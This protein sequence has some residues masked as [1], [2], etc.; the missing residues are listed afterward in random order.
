MAETPIPQLDKGALKRVL[1]IADL[2]AVGYG[3]LGSSI[4]YALGITAMFA[5]GAT[6]I[7]LGLAGVVFICTALSYAE[8]TS[9]YHE[10][11]GS[12][13]YARHAF[14]D[15]ISF[16]AGWGLL[17]DYVVTIAISA[18]TIGPYLANFFPFLRHG[19]S[20][21]L[22]AIFLIAVLFLLNVRGIKQSTRIS[23]MLMLV[24]LITQLLIIGI[25]VVLTLNLPHLISQMKIGVAGASWSPSWHDFMH[26]TAMAMVA[27]TGIESIAQLGAETKKPERNVPRAI[28]LTMFVLI[29]MYMALSLVT[30]SV[31]S[32]QELGS[33]YAQ[34]PIT[35]MVGKLPIGGHLLKP[36]I[37]IIA[38]IVLFVASNAGLIGA[39]RLSF[40]MGE[41]YQLPR[42]FS[43]IHPKF[44]TPYAS[45]ALFA[46]VAAIIVALSG[47]KISFLADLYNFGAQIAF[48]S[49]HMSLIILRIQKPDLARPFSVPFNIRFGCHR[50]PI[51]AIIGALATFAVWL[52]VVITKPDGRYL[53]LVWLACG[54][55]MYF[56]YRRKRNISPTAQVSLQK[57]QIPEF[58]PLQIQHILVPLRS[59][60]HIETIQMACEIA[61]LHKAKL[62]L[63]QVIELPFSIPLDSTLSNRIHT[64]E[65]ILKTAEAI[66]LDMELVVELQILRARSTADAILELLHT[67]AYDL[68][69]LGILKPSNTT[70]HKGVSLLTE[71]ILRESPCRVWVCGT[72]GGGSQNSP[73]IL[74]PKRLIL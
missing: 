60:T 54:L 46:G 21:I 49:T 43:V 41:Y 31:I 22:L 13:S 58:K 57:I 8:M 26:G 32:P 27:Y 34:D 42:F 28:I 19:T 63:L 67:G 45:L 36:W 35:G 55:C 64:A 74:F 11:G 48:F 72:V 71:R 33:T 4:F 3:D 70:T 24:T 2:F 25:G 56:T 18:F 61:K 17:L 16:I 52:L 62:T 73:Q 1:G 38:A 50:I 37:G 9:I 6:P 7:A 23:F 20:Q 12:A 69:V 39:S 53:G 68:L 44:R 51:T 47:A 29:F 59:G 10:S 65:A 15:L 14:N 5:L 30:L 66:A 40:N